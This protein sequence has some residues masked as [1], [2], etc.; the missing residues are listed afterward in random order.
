[1]KKIS[2]KKAKLCIPCTDKPHESST[3]VTLFIHNLNMIE[4]SIFRYTL[5][6]ELVLH[7]IKEAD[8]KTLFRQL[9]MTRVHGYAGHLFTCSVIW[10]QSVHF[11][12]NS[13]TRFLLANIKV[14]LI[15]T[16]NIV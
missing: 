4:L 13:D 3:S 12:R 11:P 15:G 9:T 6:H 10:L 7:V 14:P 1:M 8:R 2:S 16:Y 5:T